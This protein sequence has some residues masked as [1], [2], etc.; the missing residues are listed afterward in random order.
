M[1]KKKE[2]PIKGLARKKDAMV[3]QKSLPLFALWRSPLTLSEF[4]ILDIYLARIN[5]HHPE[6]RSVVLSRGDLEQALEVNKINIDAL[7]ERLKHL[8]GTVVEIPDATIKRGFKLVTLFEEAEA[9]LAEDG[10]WTITLECTAKA[11]K[12]FFNVESLGY[13]RYKLRCIMT[14]KSRYAYIMFT[15]IEANRY[16]KTW[17]VS[18][19]DLREVLG[20]TDETY[21]SYKRFNDLVLKKVK[22]ELDEKTDCHFTY[23]SIR[24]GRRITKLQITVETLSLPEEEDPNQITIEQWQKEENKTRDN[25]C[26]GLSDPAFDELSEEQLKVLVSLAAEKGYTGKDA[27]LHLKTCLAAAQ[28]KGA[29]HPYDYAKKILENAK[30]KA[31]KK[32]GTKFTDMPQREYDYA[33]LERQLLAAQDAAQDDARRR[34]IKKK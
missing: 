27:A 2:E 3:V 15:Y 5:S 1:A 7:K 25:I 16:R 10:L 14:I 21:K 33:D 28:E 9:E 32:T 8:M 12:Y 24:S 23:D 13:L 19:D 30:K 6:K 18:V 34:P 4:K 11:Q 20:C 31:E 26:E 29:K 17:V 22:K